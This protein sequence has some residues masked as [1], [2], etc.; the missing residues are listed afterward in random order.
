MAYTRNTEKL[1]KLLSELGVDV[2]AA[3]QV[4]LNGDNGFY[5]NYNHLPDQEL[6]KLAVNKVRTALYSWLHCLGVKG[7]YSV[8]F[9]ENGVEVE[10]K[11]VIDSTPGIFGM[12][13]LAGMVTNKR[14]GLT[15]TISGDAGN[16]SQDIMPDEDEKLAAERLMDAIEGKDEALPGSLT[17]KQIAAAAVEVPPEVDPFHL[18][19]KF[20]PPVG[21]ESLDGVV[22]LDKK[23]SK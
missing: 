19:P 14:S 5:V 11:L 6:I 15:R 18:P 21:V 4:V 7:R 12:T 10:R 3:K 22:D 8:K 16:D 23:G 9:R 1:E 13:R 17:S 2:P 20:V